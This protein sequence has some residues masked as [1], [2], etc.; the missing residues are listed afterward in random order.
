M[1]LYRLS[2][3]TPDGV[4][5]AQLWD[6]QSKVAIAPATG[7]F[8]NPVESGDLLF[9]VMSRLWEMDGASRGLIVMA[10]Q[11]PDQDT[12]DGYLDLLS[13]NGWDV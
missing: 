3:E 1:I 4:V 6:H 13:A 12:P 5:V 2:V 8:I 9:E 11:V 10:N 7:D